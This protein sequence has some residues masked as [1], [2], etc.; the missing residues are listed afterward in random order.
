MGLSRRRS[1]PADAAAFVINRH[2]LSCRTRSRQA[3]GPSGTNFRPSRPAIIDEQRHLERERPS[4][5]IDAD[6]QLDQLGIAHHLRIVLERGGDPLRVR[7]R[8]DGA[9]LGQV[10]RGESERGQHDGARECQSEGQPE[11]SGGASHSISPIWRPLGRL[12]LYASNA[13]T[14]RFSRSCARIH[15]PLAGDQPMPAATYVHL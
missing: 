4:L 11:G 9:L 2:S 5:V 12:F 14:M 3:G 6:Q 10:G 15:S 7:P 8:Q 1:H 13:L